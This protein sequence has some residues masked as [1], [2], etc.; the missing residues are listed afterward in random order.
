MTWKPG[1][2]ALNP[3]TGEE[4]PTDPAELAKTLKDSHGVRDAMTL[5]SCSICHR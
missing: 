5:T 3:K 4:Y 2:K 1:Q